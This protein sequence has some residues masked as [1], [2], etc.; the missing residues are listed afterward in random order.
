MKEAIITLIAAFLLFTIT[1]CSSE[2]QFVWTVTNPSPHFVSF[3]FY[4]TPAE[5]IYNLIF[6]VFKIA[7]DFKDIPFQGGMCERI[8]PTAD[9]YLTLE[10]GE[11]FRTSVNVGSHYHISEPGTYEINMNGFV[12]QS[13]QS[14]IRHGYIDPGDVILSTRLELLKA[15]VKLDNL[16]DFNRRMIYHSFARKGHI[17]FSNPLVFTMTPNTTLFESFLK[18]NLK[19]EDDEIFGKGG[20][21]VEI[22][23]KSTS[24]R[25]RSFRG[26]NGEQTEKDL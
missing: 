12:S 7:P 21:G 2:Y 8:E 20:I 4:N 5:G 11:S 15:P 18:Y 6:E 23:G 9:Q 1:K 13:V 26:N 25:K 24:E 3:C 10:P 14:K 16:K 17:P 22:K 19:E